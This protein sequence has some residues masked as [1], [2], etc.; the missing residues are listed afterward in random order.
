MING[1][2]IK[3]WICKNSWGSRWGDGGYFYIRRGSDDMA[4]ESMAV[5]IEF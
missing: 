5:E 2:R 3:Y 1:E 4:L